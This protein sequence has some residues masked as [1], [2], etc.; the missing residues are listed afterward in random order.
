[1]V[2]SPSHRCDA[3]ASSGRIGD[4]IPVGQPSRRSPVPPRATPDSTRFLGRSPD[5]PALFGIYPLPAFRR[6][7]LAA[8]CRTSFGCGTI[9]PNVLVCELWAVE[10]RADVP[11]V[12]GPPGARGAGARACAG[13]PA[14]AGV[15]G[16]RDG[17]RA[18]AAEPAVLPS[19][20]PAAGVEGGSARSRGPQLPRWLLASVRPS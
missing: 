3:A 19:A 4:A 18:G 10:R 6:F 12:S 2:A 20:M 16:L 13:G 1:V 7:P 8:F 17:V 14:A 9:G 11:R 5:P 15:R